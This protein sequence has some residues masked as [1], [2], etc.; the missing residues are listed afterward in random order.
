MSSFLTDPSVLQL[1]SVGTRAWF[2]DESQGWVLG[3]L[4]AQSL[5]GEQLILKFKLESQ[6]EIEFK[7]SLD[8]LKESKYA[9]LPPLDNPPILV[10]LFNLT[11]QG[12]RR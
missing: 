4:S 5:E 10:R 7:S 2:V 3:V 9:S 8:K 12:R 11:L 6:R 1:Y